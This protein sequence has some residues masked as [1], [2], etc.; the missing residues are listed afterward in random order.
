MVKIGGKFVN[1]RSL[2]TGGAPSACVC[3]CLIIILKVATD[4][5]CVFKCIWVVCVGLCG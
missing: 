2:F 4:S 5:V 3:F 1:E